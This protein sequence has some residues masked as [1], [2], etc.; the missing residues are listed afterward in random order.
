MAW[1]EIVTKQNLGRILR[2]QFAYRV[3]QAAIIATIISGASHLFHNWNVEHA[4]LDAKI[5]SIDSTAD[6]SMTADIFLWQPIEVGDKIRATFRVESY[7]KLET[8][9]IYKLVVRKLNINS[10]WHP[11]IV[12]AELI[13]DTPN[14]ES[15]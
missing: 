15:K 9:K 12:S 13:D 5:T 14:L 10:G 7:V 11:V 2:Q 8:G 6:G 1:Q 4:T 3:G